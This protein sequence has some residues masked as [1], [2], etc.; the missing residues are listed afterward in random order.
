MKVA[1]ARDLEAELQRVREENA[2]LRKRLSESSSLET[3][4]RK[5]ESRVEQLEQKVSCRLTI[6]CP[7]SAY[8][9]FGVADG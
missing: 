5:A 1:E 2:D 7:S 9:Y 6:L 8:T 4:K 3:A